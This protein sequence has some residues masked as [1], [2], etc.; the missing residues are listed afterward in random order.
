MNLRQRDY[1]LPMPTIRQASNDLAITMLERLQR[2]IQS[3][4]NEETLTAG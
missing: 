2:T 4:K 3:H 1:T